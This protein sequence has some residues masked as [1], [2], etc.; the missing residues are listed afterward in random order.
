M[1]RCD[2]GSY[3]INIEKGGDNCDVCHYKNKVIVLGKEL[4]NYRQAMLILANSN[5]NWAMSVSDK[6]EGFV[7]KMIGREHGVSKFIVS[8]YT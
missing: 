3:A 5:P 7:S 1:K 6:E 4:R 8:S 2:C